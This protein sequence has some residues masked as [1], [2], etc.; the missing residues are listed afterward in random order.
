M[1]QRITDYLDN[2]AKMFPDKEAFIDDNKSLTFKTLQENAYKIAGK[3]ISKGVSKK[4]IAVYLEKSVECICAMVGTTYSGNF[5]TVLDIHMPT[6]RIEKILDTL[7]PEIIITDK[8]HFGGAKN[9]AGNT[10]VLTIE[11][12]L[13]CELNYQLVDEA[14]K[15]IIATDILYVLFTSGSTGNPKGVIISHQAVIAYTDWVS[16]TF[17]IDNS[18][19][20]GNQTPFYF[21]MSGLDIYQTL[22]RGCSMYII[23]RLAFS[24]PGMLVDYL[25]DKKINTVFWVPTALCM[26]ANLGALKGEHLPELRLVMFGGEVMPTKQLNMWMDE[27]P[28]VTFVNQYGP[29]EMT[30]ICAYYIVNRRIPDDEAVPIG[31]PS[32]HYDIVILDENDNVVKEGDVGELCGRGP[33]LASGYYNEPQKTKEAFVQNPLNKAYPETMYRTGDLVKKNEYGELVYIT[34]K[35]FQIKHLGHRIELGEIETAA[36]ALDGIERVCCI[37]DSKNSKIVMVYTGSADHSGIAKKLKEKLPDYMIPNVIK[38]LDD[39]PINLNG[40]I[41]RAKLKEEIC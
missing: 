25:R 3:I 28:N 36:S 27:Y 26:L 16:E 39:M 19:V 5:Y 13:S 8:N 17:G 30:D 14:K 40:K 6:T 38:Q 1:Q 10:T 9:F 41:D 2:T 37:Y 21:V 33:S 23:P 15:K 12:L 24:F 34:R 20:F 31:Y 4:P 11:A 35:D 7:K 22:A 18:T 32:S 29:T